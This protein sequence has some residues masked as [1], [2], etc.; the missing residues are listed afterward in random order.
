MFSFKKFF[1]EINQQVNT[2]AKK[3]PTSLVFV[4][5][6]FE[7]IAKDTVEQ[8][9]SLISCYVEKVPVYFV[10]ELASQSNI[11]YE[12]LSSAVISKLCI[13]RLYLMTPELYLDN[14]LTKVIK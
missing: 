1:E 8:F 3:R 2:S 12:Q 9:V 11:L 14:F 7:L 13:K 10:I 5:K 4:F 6:Q